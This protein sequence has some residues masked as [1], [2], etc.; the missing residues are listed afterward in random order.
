MLA[1]DFVIVSHIAAQ[2][3]WAAIAAIIL[4]AAS[5]VV[6]GIVVGRCR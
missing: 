6:E 4:V 3:I 5:G 2:S 1:L